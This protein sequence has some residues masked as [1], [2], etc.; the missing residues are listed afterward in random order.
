MKIPKTMKPLTILNEEVIRSYLRSDKVE[1]RIFSEIDS[2]N[3]E[4]RRLANA[5]KSEAVLLLAEQQSS[6]RGRLGRSF[7][8]PAGAGIYMTYL[9]QPKASAGD[10]ISVTT[11]AA[12]AVLRAMRAIPQLADKDFAIKWVNDIYLSSK[13]LCGILTEA[14]TD[15]ADGTINSIWI[16]I[17]INVHPAAFPPEL[18]D[19]ATSLGK[20]APD[21]NELIAKILNELL[22]ILENPD[23]YAHMPYYRANSMVIGKQVNTICADIIKP[24]TVLDVDKDGG[25]VILRADG[26]VET[27]HSG[28]VSLRFS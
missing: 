16:G 2:T 15:P 25:L 23:R 7:Y 21:R 4:A 13:K 8:S 1:I 9:W 20:D 18:S 19:I 28:E 27:I 10:V 26:S 17:G 6:G 12:V 24:G 14:V 5:G 3:R 11:A 22:L